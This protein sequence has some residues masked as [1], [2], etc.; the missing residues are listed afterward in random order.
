MSH[1]DRG[2]DGAKQR[3]RDD[4][5][6]LFGRRHAVELLEQRPRL[7]RRG[8]NPTS[9]GQWPRANYRKYASSRRDIDASVGHVQVWR[10]GVS[11]GAQRL[12]DG[13]GPRRA[14]SVMIS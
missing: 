12:G 8:L 9:P 3:V 6:R 4:T 14:P 5:R 7:L 1:D 2:A 10:D 11:D 13:A